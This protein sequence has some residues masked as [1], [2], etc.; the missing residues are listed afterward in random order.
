MNLLAWLLQIEKMCMIFKTTKLF[1]CFMSKL[2]KMIFDLYEGE[3]QEKEVQE[4]S[5][6]LIKLFK[7]LIEIRT[8]KKIFSS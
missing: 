2:E 1:C 8:G 4:S 6:G 3:I 7:L 5:E